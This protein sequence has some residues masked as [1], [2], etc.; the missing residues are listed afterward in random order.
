[1]GYIKAEQVLNDGGVIVFPCDTVIGVGCRMDNAKAIRRLYEIKRRPFSQPTAVLVSD[2]EM[3]K[4]LMRNPD[5]G[6]VSILE[7]YWP[8][9]LTIVVEASDIVPSEILGGA[10]EVGIRVPDFPKLQLLISNIGIPL[11]ATSANFKGE[12]NP[13]HFD[14]VS[15][16]FLALIDYAIEEDST[17]SMASTLVRFND[18]GRI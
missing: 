11:V 4:S 16:E 2:A 3:A 5:P 9:A 12:K 6:L 7:E 15:K 17:G 18:M 8:G 13:L 14:E 10:S 1:M